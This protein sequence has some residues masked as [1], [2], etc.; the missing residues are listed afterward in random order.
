MNGGN[1]SASERGVTLYG[2][3]SERGTGWVL[4]L[5][6]NEI[7]DLCREKGQEMTP[8]DLNRLGMKNVRDLL[9]GGG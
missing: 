9:E 8:G 5:T 3:D 7:A 4:A 1:V 6:W 2:W